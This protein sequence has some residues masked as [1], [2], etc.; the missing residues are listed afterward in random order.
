MNFPSGVTA[1][2]TGNTRM[3]LQVGSAMVSKTS[4]RIIVQLFGC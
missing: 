3:A 2:V 4:L 1:W